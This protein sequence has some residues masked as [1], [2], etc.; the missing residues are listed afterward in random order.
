MGEKERLTG[1]C[2]MV[3]GSSEE[4]RAVRNGGMLAACL[5]PGSTVTYKPG[6][7]PRATVILL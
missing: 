5:P 7:L 3:R 1:L 6:L 4:A 2:D